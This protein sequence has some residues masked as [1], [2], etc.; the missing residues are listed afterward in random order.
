MKNKWASWVVCVAQR[1]IWVV[2]E[3]CAAA[4]ASVSGLRRSVSRLKVGM[5][6]ANGA[7]LKSWIRR[8]NLTNLWFLVKI[9]LNK[10]Q[11]KTIWLCSKHQATKNQLKC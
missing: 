5:S 1:A 4:S 2:W 6:R 10:T 8:N 3:L 9:Q 11:Q 7:I